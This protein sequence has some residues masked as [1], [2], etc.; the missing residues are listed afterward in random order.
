VIADVAAKHKLDRSRIFALCWLS[1]GTAT[2]AASLSPKSS[3]TGSLIAMSVF[4]P[5]VLPP[6][7]GA[8]GRAFYLYHSKEDRTCPYRMAEE[9][10][11]SLEENGAKVHLET[12]DG[13]HGWHGDLFATS[14]WGSSGWRRIAK[15]RWGVDYQSSRHRA[16]KESDLASLRCGGKSL[17]APFRGSLRAHI[18]LGRKALRCPD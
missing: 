16:P 6:L 5:K 13:G 7:A 11:S 14:A 10:K 15:W 8:Q 1:S 9:A 3:I 4:K 12:Y 17:E 18:Y 2:Y